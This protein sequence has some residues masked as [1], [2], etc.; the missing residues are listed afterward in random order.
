[1]RLTRRRNLSAGRKAEKEPMSPGG[2][3]ARSV[4]TYTDYNPKGR[5]LRD[6]R[7]DPI[8]AG[9]RSRRGDFA[10]GHLV[11]VRLSC[12]SSLLSAPLARPKPQ[13]KPAAVTAQE[14]WLYIISAEESRRLL[15]G[16]AGK[17]MR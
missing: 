12:G 15:N 16:L 10:G 14:T 8:A 11:V 3:S 2:E 1:M 17:I 7:R 9:Y 6:S 5:E 4:L 13:A